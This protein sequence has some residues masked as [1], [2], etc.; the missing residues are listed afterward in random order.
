M[1]EPT[2]VRWPTWVLEPGAE[3]LRRVPMV[4][5]VPLAPVATSR[6]QSTIYIIAIVA[7]ALLAA[8]IAGTCRFQVLGVCAHETSAP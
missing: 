7:L 8:S 6:Q 1:R 3:S 5:D 2:Q 4:E